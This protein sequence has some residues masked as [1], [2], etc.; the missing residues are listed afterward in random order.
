MFSYPCSNA[1][2][3]SWSMCV[4]NKKLFQNNTNLKQCGMNTVM[5]LGL[6]GASYDLRAI[7]CLAA[8]DLTLIH[9]RLTGSSN[10][11]KY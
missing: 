6:P 4:H 10:N 11:D 7:Y 2:M 1:I 9:Q 8:I 5:H 3:R